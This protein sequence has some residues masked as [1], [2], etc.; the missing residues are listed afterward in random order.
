MP[1]DPSPLVGRVAVMAE[2]TRSVRSGRGVVLTGAPGSGGSRVLTDAYAASR[3]SG[4][5][6]ARVEPG[7]KA[8]L[9]P[10]L[11][12]LDPADRV[13]PTEQ[14]AVRAAI[15]AA[16]LHAV[17][18]D[19]AHLLDEGAGA[20]VYDL[21]RSGTA[22]IANATGPG[23]M[24]AALRRLVE[25]ERATIAPLRPL[26]HDEVVELAGHL[27]GDPVDAELGLALVTASQ[28]RPGRLGEV[29]DDG[30][31]TGAIVLADGLW[32]LVTP[33]PAAR[34]LRAAVLEGFSALPAEQR[35]WVA[36][37]AQARELADDLARR[38]AAPH[39]ILA[40]AEG[41]WTERVADRGAS[42]IVSSP[43]ATA[44]LGSLDVRARLAVLH[45]LVDAAT[46]VDRPLSDAERVAVLHWRLELGQQTD[47]QEALSLA[48]RIDLDADL[49]ERLLRAAIDGGAPAD[50]L[51][52]EHLRRTRRPAE[53]QALIRTALP[54]A[55]DERERVALIRVQTMTTGVVER[56]SADALAALERHLAIHGSHPDLLAVRAGM[57]LL[58]A[59]PAETVRG[60]EAV[61]ATDGRSAFATAFALLQTAFARRELGQLDL[62]L[63][64]AARFAAL[65]ELDQVLPDGRALGDWLPSE[66]AV[67][68]G[69]E[70]IAAE[71]AM[72]AARDGV[73]AELRGSR[74]P[75][76]SYTLACARL[77]LGDPGAAA[78]LLR[79]ADAG[80]GG[81]REGWQP[82]ILAEL[83]IA[84]ALG[85]AVGEA[86]GVH[87]R[88]RRVECP[89]IQQ[90]RV[91]LATAQLAQVR[92]QTR[93]ARSVAAAAADRARRDGLVL[94][95]FDATF[96][97]VRYGDPDAPAAL[98]ELGDAPM[99]A[100]RAAQRAYA[101]ALVTGEG[102]AVDRAGIGLWDAGLRLFAIE[103]AARAAALGS[104]DA[105]TRLVGWNAR[106]PSLRL[107]GPV[108][109]RG[110][111]LTPRERE[112]ALLAAAGASDRAIAAELGI[113]LRT[114]QTHLGRSLAKL[115]IHS[116]TELRGLVV[117]P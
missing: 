13:P 2:L 82:R 95:A 45:R 38:I 17:Y 9:E 91:E 66:L 98:L 106:T 21:A 107:P 1:H 68:V 46:A 54:S 81:W 11:T 90:T 18:I 102:D 112:V 55:A 64:A 104:P 94:D 86:A 115:G 7:W 99:G 87:A 85:G 51:L 40:A 12:L 37:I 69:A 30:V 65:D 110:G 83:T 42:R 22:V 50:A 114:A 73:P 79:E 58:E 88:L 14:E 23:G 63:E 89:P 71:A 117:E 116:R 100:G 61:L 77:L 6:V 5:R 4:L 19:D 57:L 53:A 39:S 70:T 78:R 67:A 32:R 101:A 36:A 56:R 59:R 75:P 41:G 80:A 84:L 109:G 28:G 24:P 25:E 108:E 52:A 48:Q 62:A 15:L 31:G 8:A 27:L 92:G 3:R 33:L 35:G 113:T 29:V 111:G 20:L 47:A 16:G 72:S 44:V 74:R 26:G 43:V 34:S 96:A 60:A 76:L 10:F 103:A 93:S 105:P 97:G 49:R